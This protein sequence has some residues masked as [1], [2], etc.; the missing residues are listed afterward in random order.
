MPHGLGQKHS[1]R[2]NELGPNSSQPGSDVQDC[3]IRRPAWRPTYGDQPGPRQLIQ[4]PRGRET[5]EAE[6]GPTIQRELE[7]GRPAP[8]RQEPTDRRNLEGPPREPG[9]REPPTPRNRT[10]Q[11]P[12]LRPGLRLRE[13]QDGDRQLATRLPFDGQQPGQLGRIDA[14]SGRPTCDPQPVGNRVQAPTIFPSE[15]TAEKPVGHSD[16]ETRPG[17]PTGRRNPGMRDRPFDERVPGPMAGRPPPSLENSNPLGR[18]PELVQIPNVG[19]MRNGWL[20]H[21]SFRDQKKNK[22]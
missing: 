20:Y 4:A 8:T 11:R 22:S 17:E 2:P 16:L 15:P 6:F 13:I 3:N 10:E 21:L 18:E 7:I 12:M 9:G 5:G 19:P 14:A 1:R